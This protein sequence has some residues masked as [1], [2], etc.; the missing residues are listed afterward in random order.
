MNNRLLWA[1][2]LLAAAFVYL[3]WFKNQ[4][5]DLTEHIKETQELDSMQKISTAVDNIV[6][7]KYPLSTVGRLP[8]TDFDLANWQFGTQPELSP[9]ELFP[10]TP[11]SFKSSP[12]QFI[13]QVD[14][15]TGTVYKIPVN[16]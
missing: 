8:L 16:S 1:V 14:L 6:L 7:D 13:E 10:A 4:K 2:G 11:G 9:A 12:Q 3:R 15:E 5:N